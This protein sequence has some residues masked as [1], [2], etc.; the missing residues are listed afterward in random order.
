MQRS[1]IV[2]MFF[3]LLAAGTV[4]AVELPAIYGYKLMSPLER[5]EYKAEMRSLKSEEERQ[6]FLQE[7]REEMDERADEEGVK[8]VDGVVQK[9]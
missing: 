2:L 6:E 1:S 8:L 3:L 5:A 7:H 9:R 4:T